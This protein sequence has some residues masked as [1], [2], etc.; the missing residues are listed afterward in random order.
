ME[1]TPAAKVVG[2][3]GHPVA[4]SLSPALHNRL[5]SSLG[6]DMVYHA[7]DVQPIQVEAAVNGFRALGFTGFNV[8]IPYKEVVYGLLQY[9]DDD[10]RVIGAVNTIKIENGKLIGYNTDGQ[11]FLQSLKQSGISIY[12]RKVV[13][14][15]AGGAARA[16]GIA[17][18]GKKPE[19]ITI[20]NRT[21]HRAEALADTI[22]QFKKKKLV[23]AAQMIPNDADI[24][25]NA[26]RLGMWPNIE[27]NPLK[28][29]TLNRH[30]VVCDIVYNPRETAMLQ[31][32]K[33]QSCRTKG[34]LGMLIG[35]A[36]RAVEIWIDRPLP[37]SAWQLMIDAANQRQ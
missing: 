23:E 18:A 11:G 21:F 9:M 3:M 22:N 37:A 31:Y 16:I 32:A 24:I 6:I 29:Y 14:L 25:I 17:A 2:L 36:L 19:S 8:T 4:H 26:T 34:G 35:Q 15:G 12:G 13:I 28:G 10:A 7:F 30:T 5:Y 1:F 27:G 20:I 33:S